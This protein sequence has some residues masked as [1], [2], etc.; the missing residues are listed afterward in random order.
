MIAFRKQVRRTFDTD[1]LS[2]YLS[3]TWC[4]RYISASDWTPAG[5]WRATEG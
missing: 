5:L 4:W 2:R 1:E 3:G